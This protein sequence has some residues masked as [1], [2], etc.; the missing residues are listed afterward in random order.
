MK[1]FLLSAT[2]L[3]A[4][5]VTSFASEKENVMIS[6]KSDKIEVKSD[7]TPVDTECDTYRIGRTIAS[8]DKNGDLVL[9]SVYFTL[10]ICD[11]GF[12]AVIE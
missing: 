10:V 11:D 5:S 1:K 12:V 7:E 3:V 2:L 8:A 4:F 6:N 9:T